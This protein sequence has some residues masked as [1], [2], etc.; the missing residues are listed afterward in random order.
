[1]AARPRTRAVTSSWSRSRLGTTHRQGGESAASSQR[2]FSAPTVVAPLELLA[3][4]AC[5]CSF[6]EWWRAWCG[7]MPSYQEACHPLQLPQT[8]WHC[9]SFVPPTLCFLRKHWSLSEQRRGA[10]LPPAG[11]GWPA[12][13]LRAKPQRGSPPRW[14]PQ[15]RSS[16]FTETARDSHPCCLCLPMP[17]MERKFLLR[18]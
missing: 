13:S 17:P 11:T 7:V 2:P 5:P 6:Q 8:H 12:C 3:R 1:M 15:A 16:A 9:R 14:R 18:R 4:A 10:Q